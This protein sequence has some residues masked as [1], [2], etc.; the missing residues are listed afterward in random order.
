MAAAAKLAGEETPKRMK[1]CVAGRAI[2]PELARVVAGT[3]HNRR[4]HGREHHSVTRVDKDTHATRSAGI[5]QPAGQIRRGAR[6]V[7]AP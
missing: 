3:T 1:S 6:V 2:Y 5:G 4:V 7:A